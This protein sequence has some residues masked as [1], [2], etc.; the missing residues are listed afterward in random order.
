[1]YEITLFCA[2]EDQFTKL[3]ELIQEQVAEAILPRKQIFYRATDE[4]PRCQ[5]E[6][7]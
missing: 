6:V 1:M 7:Q 4:P 5:A 3:Y 2:D